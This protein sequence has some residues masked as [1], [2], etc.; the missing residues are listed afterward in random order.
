VT[1]GG[2][3]KRGEKR[4]DRNGRRRARKGHYLFLK[5]AKRISPLN[6]GT[7]A[8]AHNLLRCNLRQGDSLVM[9][10]TK[11]SPLNLGQEGGLWLLQRSTE[12]AEK[13]FYIDRTKKGHSESEPARLCDIKLDDTSEPRPLW[14][15]DRASV[16]PPAPGK[17]KQ[18]L[19][20]KKS[21]RQD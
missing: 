7:W 11:V 3:G 21:R 14:G 13:V 19:N 16:C 20:E 10:T 18:R 17:E 2:L 15:T 4:G 9:L 1:A 5:I 6:Q 12:T 8:T